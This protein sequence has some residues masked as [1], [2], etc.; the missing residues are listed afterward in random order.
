MRE[1]VG[2]LRDP[3]QADL[4]KAFELVKDGVV[5][6]RIHLELPDDLDRVDPVCAHILFRCFQEAIT[7][8]IKHANA[9]NLRVELKRSEAGWEMLVNDDGRGAASIS[10]GN[11]LRGMMERL[12]E[13]GGKLQFGSRPGEGF[14]LR[15]SIPSTGGTA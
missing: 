14:T 6:P 3:Q 15:A 11:G 5:A 4:R 2:G 7:N 13:V 9:S 10:P 1:V 12:E 8:A